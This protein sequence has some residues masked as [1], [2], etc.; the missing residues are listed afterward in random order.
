MIFSKFRYKVFG[1]C[2]NT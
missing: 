1:D 2:R